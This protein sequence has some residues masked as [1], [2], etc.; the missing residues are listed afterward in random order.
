MVQ[1]AKAWCR[2]PKR[3]AKQGVY[4][5]S[6][7]TVKQLGNHLGQG[8]AQRQHEEQQ[9]GDGSQQ[10]GDAQAVNEGTAAPDLAISAPLAA[11]QQ[12]AA[13]PVI[14]LLNQLAAAA[15]EAQEARGLRDTNSTSLT[16]AACKEVTPPLKEDL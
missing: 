11:T 4:S 1:R 8:L 6:H 3:G 14:A 12:Q 10:H 5:A 2:E 15:A 7:D 16:L 13:S 9:A